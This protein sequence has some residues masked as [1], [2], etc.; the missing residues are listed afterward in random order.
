MTKRKTRLS[1]GLTAACI[2]LLCA[3]VACN[4]ITKEEKAVLPTATALTTAIT[5]TAPPTSTAPVTTT[6]TAV[7]TTA[8]QITTAVTCSATEQGLDKTPTPTTTTEQTTASDTT[9]PLTTTT[10]PATTT[11]P[12]PAEPYHG[13]TSGDYIYVNG[14]GWVFNEGGGGEGSVNYEMY[15]N[16]NKIGYFG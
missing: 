1:I 14:F 4:G 5:T 8:P 13:Q 9:V 2:A 7:T 3:A 15:C 6:T 11:V 12:A 10:T 16:G